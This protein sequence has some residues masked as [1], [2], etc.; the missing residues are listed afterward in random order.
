MESGHGDSSKFT[1]E[2]QRE[3]KGHYSSLLTGCELPSL[4]LCDHTLQ[5]HYSH[6]Q[7]GA[8]LYEI[9]WQHNHR[10]SNITPSECSLHDCGCVCAWRRTCVCVCVSLC[11]LVFQPGLWPGNLSGDTGL[12]ILPFYPRWVPLWPQGGF[13]LGEWEWGSVRVHCQ[14]AEELS[15]TV[16]GAEA[17]VV[18]GNSFGCVHVSLQ[19][20]VDLI[21][22]QEVD[23]TSLVTQSFSYHSH[24]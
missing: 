21:S 1:S 17:V 8:H 18:K 19:A 6:S 13:Q 4:L 10:H 15:C 14:A 20:D 24:E 3:L 12:F 16:R 11:L 7:A 5:C 9:Y 2:P 22:Q 23:Q